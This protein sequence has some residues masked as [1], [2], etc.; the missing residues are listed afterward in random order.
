[1]TDKEVRKLKR[2]ELLEIL[3]QQKKEIVRLEKQ[4][5]EAEE[6]LQ[7]RDIII[8]QAGSIAEA[9]L[10]LNH[11]FEDAQNAANQ[12]LENV[13]RLTAQQKGTDRNDA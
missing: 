10:R 5:K 13:R 2:A 9:S 12:Y 3:V 7:S 6:K 8:Q 11:I 4:L 1:M